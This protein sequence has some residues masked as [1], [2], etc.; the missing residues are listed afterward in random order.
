MHYRPLNKA[1]NNDCIYTGLLKMQFYTRCADMNALGAIM[2]TDQCS[3]QYTKN[4]NKNR[5][6][7]VPTRQVCVVYPYEKQGLP[8]NIVA[9]RIM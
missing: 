3:L 1:V 7:S 9:A 2:E 8:L 5:M 4:G 6:V